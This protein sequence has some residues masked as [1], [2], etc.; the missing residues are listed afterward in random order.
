M[1]ITFDLLQEKFEDTKGVIGGC[2]LMDRQYYGVI[3][4]SK[5]MDRQY[6]GKK[7]KNKRT[8]KYLQ[9]TTHKTKD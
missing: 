6:Y 3:S 1:T 9:N 2:N 4:G 7:G 5:S 8:I